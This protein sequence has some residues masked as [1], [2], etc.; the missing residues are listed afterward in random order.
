MRILAALF[1]GTVAVA[2]ACGADGGGVAANNN[3]TGGSGAGPDGA[4]GGSGG[5]TGGSTPTCIIGTGQ[6]SGLIPQICQIGG[7]WSSGAE[8]PFACANGACTGT[9]KPASTECKFGKSRTCGANAEWEAGIDCEFGCENGLCRTACLAGEFNCYGNEVRQC[10]PGPPAKWVAKAPATTCSASAGTKCDAK[11]G[12]CITVPTVGG[13]TPTGK[14][15]QYATF[16]TGETA[17]LG[18]YDVTSF[19]D[20]VYVNRS[21]A[22]LDV[23][24]VTLLDTDGDGDLEPNQHPD[25]PD[26]PGPVEQRTIELVITYTKAA[27]TTPLGPASQSSLHAQGADKIF[28]LG[29]T[30]NGA[31]SEFVYGTKSSTIV[32]QPTATTPV[33]SFLGFGYGDGQ[34]YSGNE[35]ARRVYSFHAPTKSWV[36]EFGYPNLAGSHMDGMEVVISPKTGEQ[37]VYVSDMTSDFIGQ[38]RNDS[39][40]GWVQENLFEYNDATSSAI[41]GFGFGTLNHFWGSSGTF[42][43]ELGGGDIQKDLEPCENGKPACGDNLPACPSGHFCQAGCC[44]K[45]VR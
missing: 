22:N 4:V 29:P 45:N 28:M 18:G 43:Y 7:I 33:M 16:K 19:G 38:Y 2:T 1:L 5:G 13:T 44:K 26:N 35:S 23:Y 31:I 10:D 9:C 34:W 14:Y 12:T 25:N 39:V 20:F 41:E 32:I 21:S 11:T 24:K 36:A 30:H 37:Y 27:D 6:C 15:Y 42:V 17:F 40:Q 8:C 3:G